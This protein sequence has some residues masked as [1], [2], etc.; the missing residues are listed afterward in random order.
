MTPT[1]SKKTYIH[2]SI[3]N[4]ANLPDLRKFYIESLGIAITLILMRPKKKKRKSKCLFDLR[5]PKQLFHFRA[6]R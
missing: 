5:Q 3:S 6:Q 1:D 4:V 2:Y